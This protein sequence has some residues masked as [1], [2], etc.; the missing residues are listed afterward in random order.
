MKSL[1]KNYAWKLIRIFCPFLW[2]GIKFCKKQI[3][4]SML[5][6][7]IWIIYRIMVR[8]KTMAVEIIIIIHLIWIKAYFLWLLKVFYRGIICLKIIIIIMIICI[9]KIMKMKN[10]TMN[11]KIIKKIDC[12]F[13]FFLNALLRWVVK[14]IFFGYLLIFSFF[15]FLLF[16]YK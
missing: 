15:L 8:I 13:H 7:W 3:L 14:Y 4:V 2:V 6:V 5:N 10:L 9:N 11:L 1:F 16:I 12:C